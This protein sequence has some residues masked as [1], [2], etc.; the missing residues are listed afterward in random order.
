MDI[1]WVIYHLTHNDDED[2]TSVV[3]LDIDLCRSDQDQWDRFLTGLSRNRTVTNIELSRGYQLPVVND[4]DLR[5]LFRAL[6]RIPRLAKVKLQSFTT[7]DLEQ[8]RSLFEDNTTIEEIWIE[9]GHCYRDDTGDNNN[10]Y[11]D[12]LN[13]DTIDTI[14]DNEGAECYHQYGRF[15]GFLSSMRCLHRLRI[16]MPSTLSH[17]VPLAPLLMVSS[18]LQ[19]LV[20]ETTSVMGSTSSPTQRARIESRQQRFRALMLALQSNKVL[21]VLDIDFLISF[22]DFREVATMLQHN[23]TLT[24]LSLRLDPSTAVASALVS[25]LRG[26]GSNSSADFCCG[27][28]P[29]FHG[30]IRRFF[31]ALK[32]NTD[33]SLRTFTQYNF[34]DRAFLFSRPNQGTNKE[35]AKLARELVEIGFEM[36]EGNLTLER[37]SF[38]L[39]DPENPEDLYP[40]EKKEL[41]LRLNERGRKSVQHRG[42]R[43]R[44]SRASFVEQLARH[45]MD[46]L[47][48]VYYYICANPSICKTSLEATDRFASESTNNNNNDDNETSRIVSKKRKVERVE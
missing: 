35:Y 11:D 45:S 28:H 31:E 3:D 29:H 21:K 46:D 42:V 17:E 30:S 27:F 16:E 43:E 26:G 4:D 37:F 2:F 14:D 22:L 39:T 20:L 7:F 5:R 12:D 38:F 41:F 44:V 15:L 47:D 9:N 25:D 24:D 23:T 36:L 13:D 34:E 33:S 1:E 8:S 18:K 19:S 6:R 10:S 40:R 48:G 32:T